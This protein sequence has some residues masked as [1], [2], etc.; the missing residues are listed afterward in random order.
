[1]TRTHLPP[2][3]RA[4]RQGPDPVSYS[5]RGEPGFAAGM[6]FAAFLV[7]YAGAGIS[8]RSHAERETLARYLEDSASAEWRR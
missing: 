5:H 7:R 3:K 1:M 2:A 6:A 8:P 4:P